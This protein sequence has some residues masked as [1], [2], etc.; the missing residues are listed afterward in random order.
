M[1]PAVKNNWAKASLASNLSSGPH[2]LKK[3]LMVLDIIFGAMLFYRP[4]VLMT[5]ARGWEEVRSFHTYGGRAKGRNTLA[6]GVVPHRYFG[7]SPHLEIRS[8]EM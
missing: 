2:K 7:L 3:V 6:T 1:E 4:V 8:S 5:W